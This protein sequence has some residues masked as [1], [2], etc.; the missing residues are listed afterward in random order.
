[1]VQRQLLL[2]LATLIPALLL[3]ALTAC[4]QPTAPGTVI[5]VRHADKKSDAGNSD[6]SAIGE[7]RADDLAVLLAGDHVAAVYTTHFCRTAQ[8][9]QPT[10]ETFDLPLNLID[11]PNSPGVSGCM[12]EIVVPTDTLPLTSNWEAELAEYLREEEAGKVVLVVAHSTSA[13]KLVKEL[14][15]SSVC[16]TFIPLIDGICKIDESEYNHLFR[17]T[18]PVDGSE[19]SVTHELYG[20]P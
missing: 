1:M 5:V 17:V 7:T 16:P 10:A 18:V 4:Q 2:R 14:G 20:A 9:G 13:P 8:T 19:A 11:M 12:P 3:L 6:L 15:A